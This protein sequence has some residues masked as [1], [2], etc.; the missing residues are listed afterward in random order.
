MFINQKSL[1]LTDVREHYPRWFNNTCRNKIW[2]VANSTPDQAIL[3]FCGLIFSECHDVVSSPHAQMIQQHSTGFLDTVLKSHYFDGKIW[4][5]AGHHSNL[6]TITLL[7]VDR[8][9]RWSRLSRA[10]GWCVCNVHRGYYYR[11]VLSEDEDHLDYF[12]NLFCL[13]SVFGK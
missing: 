8:C 2:M 4:Y 11:I 6:S 12:S 1:L 13:F 3:A 7:T 10:D 9:S 5:C